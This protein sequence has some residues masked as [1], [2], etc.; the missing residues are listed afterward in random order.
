[1][2]NEE[3]TIL[4]IIIV[5]KEGKEEEKKF[6]IILYITLIFK[7]YNQFQFLQKYSLGEL[8]NKK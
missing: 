1:M 3:I 7:L 6:C 4:V 5:L 2:W 8:Y